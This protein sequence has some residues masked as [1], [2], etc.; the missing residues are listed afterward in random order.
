MKVNYADQKWLGAKYNR[1]TVI[2]FEKV[3]R[4]KSPSWNWIVRCDCGTLKSVSPYRVLNGNTKSCGCYKKD[5]TIEYN[6]QS[7]KIHGG[8]HTRLYHIWRGMKSRCFNENNADYKRYGGR[9]ITVCDEWEND[10]AVFRDW[11]LCNGYSDDLSIDRIDVDGD[12][13][14]EN[15]RWTDWSTQNKNRCS[16]IN[17]EYNG[18][19]VNLVDLADMVGIRYGTLY[20]RIHLYGWPID[21]AI[22]TPVR[23]TAVSSKNT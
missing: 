8:R 6:Q 15:C 20:Q 11:A 3:K 19:T 2:A 10:F 22:K 1:L 14:P 16:S 21:R 7:K 17:V 13:C 12:Y 5:Q 9:G 23:K 18:K 4:G